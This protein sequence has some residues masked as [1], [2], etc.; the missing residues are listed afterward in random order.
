MNDI[1][2]EL[3]EVSNNEI[4]FKFYED[5]IANRAM[6]ICSGYNKGNGKFDP[7]DLPDVAWAN[8]LTWLTAFGL[9]NASKISH[10]DLYELINNKAVSKKHAFLLAKNNTGIDFTHLLE[11][12][13]FVNKIDN[14]LQSFTFKRETKSLKVDLSLLRA[15]LQK[16]ELCLVIEERVSRSGSKVVEYFYD[17]LPT[18][19]INN[20]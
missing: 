10:A 18:Q 2:E 14:T 4:L 17:I 3:D 11:S 16:L 7:N 13:K 1:N 5:V 20:K 8:H 19:T 9:Y 12:C 15:E 6:T